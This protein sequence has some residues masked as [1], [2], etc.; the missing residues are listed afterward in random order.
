MDMSSRELNAVNVFSL[1]EVAEVLQLP[2]SRI[3]DWTIGR[4]LEIIPKVLAA[5]GTGSRNLYSIEDV[6]V[7]GFIKQL[8]EDGFSSKTIKKLLVGHGETVWYVLEEPSR[9]RSKPKVV[10]E[11]GL[12]LLHLGRLLKEVDFLVITRKE[13]KLFVEFQVGRVAWSEVAK[14]EKGVLGKY[15]LDVRSLV[16]QIDERVAKLR[17]RR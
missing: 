8:G 12:I 4:P 14:R 11:G 17:G 1:G 5:H 7:M 2:K 16:K 3:K 15:I 13:G 9:G 6:Y 10:E